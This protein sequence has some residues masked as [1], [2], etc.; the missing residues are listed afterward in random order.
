MPPFTKLSTNDQPID[1]KSFPNE[2]V[3]LLPTAT[4][5]TDDPN[6]PKDIFSGRGVNLT[7]NTKL[8]PY[9]I[10]HMLERPGV[11]L[12]ICLTEFHLIIIYVD[13]IKAV[14]TLDGRAVYSMPLNNIIGCERALG[15]S[16]DSLSSHIW[17]FSNNHLARLNMKNELCRIWQIYLDRLQFDEARQ[18]C[19][20][21]LMQTQ[22][23][24]LAK[25]QPHFY[26]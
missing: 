17:I 2:V 4:D 8:I 13:R 6:R 14:N 16:R 24:G 12:G 26:D 20:E 1:V 23:R 18:F 19:Q 9:P 11:P 7:R 3:S 15:I 5:N 25:Q 10:I 21:D 22:S